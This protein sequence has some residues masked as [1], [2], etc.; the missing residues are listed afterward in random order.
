MKYN[1]VSDILHGDWYFLS[2]WIQNFGLTDLMLF[3][4]LLQI[5]LYTNRII[6]I[7]I[8]IRIASL[9]MEGI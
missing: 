4:S 9:T 8:I 5:C 1:T 7:A 6:S 2:Y 3:F